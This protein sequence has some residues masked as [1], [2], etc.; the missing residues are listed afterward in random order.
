MISFKQFLQEGRVQSYT[1][2]QRFFI[3]CWGKLL[4]LDYERLPAGND[5]SKNPELKRIMSEYD[6][7]DD[8]ALEEMD[9]WIGEGGSMNGGRI[10]LFSKATV[11]AVLKSA[12]HKAGESFTLYRFDHTPNKLRPNSWISLSRRDHGYDGVRSEYSMKPTDLII[13]ADE[14]ADNDEVIVST[15]VLIGRS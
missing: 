8:D 14:L 3:M 1:P 15:N 9:E 12:Q 10:H 13:D 4:Y 2:L 6:D 7:L 11:D 5:E